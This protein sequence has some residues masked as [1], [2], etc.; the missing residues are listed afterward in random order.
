MLDNII[1]L[2]IIHVQN[3]VSIVVK[4]VI[5][6]GHFYIKTMNVK[7]CIAQKPVYY[8]KGDVKKNINILRIATHNVKSNISIQKN[9]H[10]IYVEIS[11]SVSNCVKRMEYVK[12]HIHKLKFCGNLNSHILNILLWEMKKR[13]VVEALNQNNLIMNILIVA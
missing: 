12:L 6:I 7:K 11:M 13:N 10:I 8:V 4:N 3:S 1:V 9:N 2:M 5:K